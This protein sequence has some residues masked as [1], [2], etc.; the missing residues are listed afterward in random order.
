[1]KK[2]SNGK[3]VL[4]GMPKRYGI[5][6]AFVK[7]FELLGFTVIDISFDDENFRY[8]H[9]GEKIANLYHKTVLRDRDFKQKLKF[10]HQ[11]KTI[12][13][14]LNNIKK[15][16]DFAIIIRPDLYPR[17][18]IE[19]AKNKCL[20]IFAYQWDGLDIFPKVKGLVCLFDRF[21]VF[22][23]S[24]LKFPNTTGITNFYFSDKIFDI[25][26]NPTFLD[27][28][29]IGVYN[30][31]RIDFVCNFLKK[32]NQL[33]VETLFE[34]FTEKISKIPVNYRNIPNLNYILDKVS[35]DHVFERSS[36]SKILVD[37]V[38]SNHKGLSLRVF[39]ALNANKKLITTNPEVKKYEFFNDANILI[40]D[41]E[42]SLEEIKAF[43]Q[44]PFEKLPNTMI[45]KYSFENWL[46][47]IINPDADSKILLPKTN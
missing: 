38:N 13:D 29:Y 2:A 14:R 43:L 42:I 34:I 1:M 46:E 6:N 27:L 47:N 8:R 33:N 32:I 17:E 9:I 20:K 23:P 35:F 16:A 26:Q 30:E 15:K 28:Y 10:K 3:T 44:I 41:S 45:S 19:K 7:N 4:F 39:E 31:N 12:E 25:K 24:D 22:D 40:Y 21:F 5:Y 11:K 36:N 37:F 18:I